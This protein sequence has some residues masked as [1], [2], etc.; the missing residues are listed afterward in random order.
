MFD[1][2]PQ[3]ALNL[4]F[5]DMFQY[6]PEFSIPSFWDMADSES[7]TMVW[8]LTDGVR[9]ILVEM[10]LVQKSQNQLFWIY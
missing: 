9:F 1:L 4:I 10:K 2:N 3:P 7:E 5:S 8:Y 6:V